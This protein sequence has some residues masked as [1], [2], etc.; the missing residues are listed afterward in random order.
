MKPLAYP[1]KPAALPPCNDLSITR[2]LINITFARILLLL[3]G[4]FTP[5]RGWLSWNLLLGRSLW[6]LARDIERLLVRLIGWLAAPPRHPWLRSLG[7]GVLN[8]RRWHL[9]AGEGCRS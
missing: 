8:V 5:F 3:G 9:A 7:T 6:Q 1:R 4:L 2:L